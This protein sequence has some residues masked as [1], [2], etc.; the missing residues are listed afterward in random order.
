MSNRND[1]GTKVVTFWLKLFSLPIGESNTQSELTRYSLNK[2]C[3]N[4]PEMTGRRIYG[5]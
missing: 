3:E 5:Q 4:Q 2:K 1:C